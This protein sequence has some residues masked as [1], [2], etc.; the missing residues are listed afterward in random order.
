M[1]AREARSSIRPPAVAGSFYPRSSKELDATI[2]ALL[3]EARAAASGELT[4]VIAPHAGYI[5]SGPVAASAF[6]KVNKADKRF[7]RVV[8]IGPPHYLPVSGIAASSAKAFATP[9]GQVP[10]D[11]EALA[12]LLDAGLVSLDDR[13][14]A[15]E[16]SLE[17]ELPFLQTVLESF[18]VIPLLVGDS[19]P[20]QVAHILEALIDRNTLL[21]VSTDL[22]HYLDDESAQARDLA[23]AAAVEGLE[24][25][26]LGPRDA[27]GF[28]AL[29]GAL[30]AA[31]EHQWRIAR[32]DLRNSSETSGDKH[33]VVGYGA[34][35]IMAAPGA[36]A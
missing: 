28:A 7:T 16:H 36:G 23:T 12:A 21:V 26:A 29:N 1:F 11:V 6:A 8:L 24:H 9:L 15:P 22:S 13:A 4:G 3:G 18:T 33:R 17:V 35:A 32:L 14:H 10:V 5:Y 27:C 25:G 34:W 19:E 2:A 20:S 30:K 31:A